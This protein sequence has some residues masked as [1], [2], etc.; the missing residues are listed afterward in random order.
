V[1]LTEISFAILPLPPAAEY[2]LLE[3]Y[4]GSTGGGSAWLTVT[5]MTGCNGQAA[6]VNSTFGFGLA[7]NGIR[8]TRLGAKTSPGFTG[9]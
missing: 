7:T 3:L 5:A 1:K 9:S 8:V 6:L 4:S 2:G